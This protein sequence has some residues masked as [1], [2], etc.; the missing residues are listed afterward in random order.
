[1]AEKISYKE[2]VIRIDERLQSLITKFDDLCNHV[3][4]EVESIDK[5]VKCL[6]DDS[7][8]RKTQWKTLLFIASSTAGITAFI[9]QLINI[10]VG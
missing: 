1:M 5:R 2:L 4:H 7:L 10:L 8:V 3:N 9:V 6:E